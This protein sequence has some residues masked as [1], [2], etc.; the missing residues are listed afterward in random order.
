MVTIKEIMARCEVC[1]NLD[2]HKYR[3]ERI[4]G[5]FIKYRCVDEYN[6][7]MFERC[8]RH[9][10]SEECEENPEWKENE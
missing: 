7:I 9:F 10:S 6:A 2:N 5:T 3:G 4:I 8:D 1:Q